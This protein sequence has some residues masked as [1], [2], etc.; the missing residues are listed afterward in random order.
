[1][2]EYFV[3]FIF[4]SFLG[5]VYECI[6]CTIKSGHWENR[7]FLIGPVC[8]IYGFGAIAAWVI[9]T[10]LDIFQNGLSGTQ[11]PIGTIF[12]I[13]AGGTAI[14]EYS[15]SWLLE[16]VFNAKWWDYSETPLNINGRICIPATCAFGVAGVVIVKYFFPWYARYDAMALSNTTV[17]EF[18]ALAFMMILGMDIALTEAS[19]TSLLEILDEAQEKFDER[20]EAGV[21]TIASVPGTVMEKA[22]AGVETISSVPGTVMEKAKSLTPKLSWRQS[23]HLNSIT[24][25]TKPQHSTRAMQ[26]K[27]AAATIK[28]RTLGKRKKDSNNDVDRR[29]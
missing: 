14:M 2:T 17:T 10:R 23:Y 12:V 26:L 7:G 15:I 9:F 28:D 4:F 13:C 6:Y 22:A 18:V 27:N 19:L 16:R 5:W 25:F 11:Q 1:M 21:V 3:R 24:K 29:R 8:P 20:M